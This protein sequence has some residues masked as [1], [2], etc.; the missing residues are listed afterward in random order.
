MR[1]IKVHEA[2]ELTRSWGRTLHP[3]QISRYVA[4]MVYHL[5]DMSWIRPTAEWLEEAET[6]T[7]LQMF[8]AGGPPVSRLWSM[9]LVRFSRADCSSLGSDSVHSK[10]CPAGRNTSFE[11][12]SRLCHRK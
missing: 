8:I 7:D 6:L 10:W 4:Q 5:A 9:L 2:K 1:S 12:Q 11:P 3:R